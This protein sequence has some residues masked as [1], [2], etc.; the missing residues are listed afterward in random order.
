MQ[1]TN[2]QNRINELRRRRDDITFAMEGES[3]ESLQEMLEEMMECEREL[4]SEL[5][6]FN[7]AVAHD[8]AA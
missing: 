7:Q 2:G 3:G 6:R 1:G 8:S 4:A 5:E